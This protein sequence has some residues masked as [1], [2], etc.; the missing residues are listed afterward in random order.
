MTLKK[1]IYFWLG[2]F[3]VFILFMLLF[4][5]I[6][7]PF[8]AGLILAY[9]L[10][11]IADKL[12]EIGMSRT[13]ATLTILLSFLIIFVVALLIMFPLL[14]DQLLQLVAALPE[15]LRKL[16]VILNSVIGN[17][18]EAIGFTTDKLQSQMGGLVTQA[19]SWLGTLL[20]S[21]WSSSQA[22]LSLL[23]LFVITPV[24]AFYILL[25]WDRMMEKIDSWLPR[26]QHDTIKELAMEMHRAV[27]GFIRGQSMMCLILGTFYAVSLMAVGLHYGLLIG[28]T[29]GIVSFIP[30]VGALVGFLLSIGVAIAQFWPDY[31]MIVTVFIIFSIGQFLEGNILQPKLL[32]N[33]IGLHPVW[34]MFALLAFGSLLGFAGMLIAIPAAAVVGVL[35]RFALEQYLASKL[36]RGAAPTENTQEELE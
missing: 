12:E 11:P 16:Q 7:L 18:L 31:F 26:D 24:V 27:G 1:K 35:A 5:D 33:S 36:Y 13:W 19:A 25:D 29:A 21:I 9:L 28:F 15:L 23:S 10:D 34:L 17:R 14:G 30:Y 2:T 32:G 6:L 3:A 20:L 22:L 8:I 4:Q